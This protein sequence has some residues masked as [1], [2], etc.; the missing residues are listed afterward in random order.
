MA[1]FVLGA[2]ATRGASFAHNPDVHCLPPL[3]SDFFTQLQRIATRKHQAL[4]HDVVR[5]TVNFFGTNFGVTMETVFSTLENTHRIVQFAG[6]RHGITAEDLKSRRE[7]LVQAIAIVMEEALTEAGTSRQPREC[8]Y[9]EHL[10]EQMRCGDSVVSFNYDCL[11]DTTLKKHGGHCWNARYG[12]CL[13]IGKDRSRLT[14][15]DYWSPDA[16]PL[17]SREQTLK[18]FKLH[19][20]L[21]FR[22]SPKKRRMHLKERPYTT[23]YGQL[24]FDIIPPESVKDYAQEPFGQLWREA[25]REIYR[26]RTLVLVGYSFPRTD[27]H[28]AALFRVS[29]RNEGISTV[30]IVNPDRD[31]RQR[32]R[33]ILIRG[34]SHDTRIVEYERLCD[35]ATVARETWDL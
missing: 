8:G 21:H 2:G 6:N 4:I 7:R 16:V 13:P 31:A 26:A 11:L 30:V 17:V 9:H 19:G 10:V 20:S 23:Q 24:K 29:V 18:V 27:L 14:G 33:E 22:Y 1:L 32:I 5:D 28:S 12:Y 3:D 35:F 15:Y 25:S 34:I